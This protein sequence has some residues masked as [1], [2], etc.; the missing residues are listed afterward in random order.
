MAYICSRL[1]CCRQL[2]DRQ[3]YGDERGTYPKS[4]RKL[5][6]IQAVKVMCYSQDGLCLFCTVLL[7]DSEYLLLPFESDIV[8]EIRRKHFKIKVWR[9]SR[10]V[11]I[12][13]IGLPLLAKLLVW[14]EI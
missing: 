5:K 6:S 7:T 1:S 10:F 11:K 13:R 4:V 8:R 9:K 2:Y 14:R 12:P 3:G